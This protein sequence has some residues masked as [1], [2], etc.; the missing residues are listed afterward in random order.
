MD[1]RLSHNKI[2]NFEALFLSPIKN[3]AIIY[4][5]RYHYHIIANKNGF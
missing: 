5:D 4:L 2:H 1:L 3:R